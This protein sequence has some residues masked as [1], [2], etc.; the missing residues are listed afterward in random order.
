MKIAVGGAA[1]RTGQHIVRSVIEHESARL[2]AAVERADHPLIGKSVSQVAGPEAEASGICFTG[3]LQDALNQSDVLI[4]FSVPQGASERIDL[5]AEAGV[6]LVVGMTGLDTSA[7]Q[8]LD[9]ASQK[10]AV[11][12]APNMSVGVNVLLHVIRQAARMLGEEYD[13][14]IFEMHHKGKVDSP[15]GTALRLAEVV[16]SERKLDLGLAAKHG[17]TGALGPRPQDEIGLHAARGGDVVGD[18][19]AIFAGGGERLEFVHRAHN[20]DTFA[21]GAVRAA[22]WTK[23][24]KPGLYGMS[25]VLEGAGE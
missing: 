1:G 22:L 13:F 21:R 19:I 15:S 24:R 17:R 12:A 6:S 23:D 3:D 4:D 9:R 11:V 14:E 8:A 7:H 20:R 16:A 2:A 25:D 18:H 5:A 10:V